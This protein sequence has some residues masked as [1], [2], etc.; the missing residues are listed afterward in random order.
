M[1][2]QHL[3]PAGLFPASFVDVL[4]AGFL[5]L[6][7]CCTPTPITHIPCTLAHPR[8]PSA[9]LLPAR[10]FPERWFP[11][12]L[13]PVL[14]FRVFFSLHTCSQFLPHNE[15]LNIVFF[16]SLP[17]LILPSLNTLAALFRFCFLHAF[18]PP[19]EQRKY[20]CA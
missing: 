8:F 13:F 5:S 20:L 18:L 7:V 9:Y 6:S 16:F 17:A 19:R 2:L 11:A 15:S 4:W 3:V 14:L 1:L 12:R 10:W